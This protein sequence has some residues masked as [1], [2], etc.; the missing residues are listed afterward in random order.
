VESS[1]RSVL[2]GT[3]GKKGGKLPLKC[4]SCQCQLGTAEVVAILKSAVKEAVEV[5]EGLPRD[6][7]LGMTR[8]PVQGKS[9]ES[10]KNQGHQ[11]ISPSLLRTP[12]RATTDEADKT[13]STLTQF[14]S[15]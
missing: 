5:W 3:R 10:P 4:Q 12:L 11:P 13:K 6:F 7:L 15:P 9:L 8:P 2:G 1:S 14:V